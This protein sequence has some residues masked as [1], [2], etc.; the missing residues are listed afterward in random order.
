M[1]FKLV[2]FPDGHAILGTEEAIG[3]EDIERIR[4]L[5]DTWKAANADV[6]IIGRLKVT[7]VLDVE[8]DLEAK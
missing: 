3:P 7:S 8:L 2:V 5:W 4:V 6:L 1:Q